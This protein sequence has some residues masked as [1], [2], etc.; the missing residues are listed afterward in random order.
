[1]DPGLHLGL[2]SRRV[3]ATGRGRRPEAR[4]GV[5]QELRASRVVLVS[6]APGAEQLEALKIALGMRFM[7]SPWS[8]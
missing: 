1:M 8:R 7:S 4:P 6:T 3:R 5:Q 2:G